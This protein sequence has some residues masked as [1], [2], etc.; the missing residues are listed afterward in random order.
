MVDAEIQ[1][2]F[3]ENKDGY[4]D[5][6]ASSSGIDTASIIEKPSVED[7]DL[8]SSE[9]RECERTC[10]RSIEDRSITLTPS[11]PSTVESYVA[12]RLAS[13]ILPSPIFDRRTV[14]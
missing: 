14:L 5:C 9:N 2:D 4:H 11:S 8:A 3:D 7:L 12:M 1:V 13:T 10:D 6:D